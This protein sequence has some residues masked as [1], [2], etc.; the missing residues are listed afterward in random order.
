VAH[1]ARQRDPS[2]VCSARLFS[3]LKCLGRAVKATGFEIPIATRRPELIGPGSCRSILSVRLYDGKGD[4][5]A[6]EKPG[7]RARGL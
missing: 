3:A 7:G 2:R 4:G 1:R 6:P 5:A